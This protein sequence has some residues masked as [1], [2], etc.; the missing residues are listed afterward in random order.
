MHEDREYAESFGNVAEIYER[1]RPGY[2][3]ALLQELIATAP[4]EVLDVGC[5]TG[6]LAVEFM[7][8][9]H[10]LG[11]EPDR[12]MAAVAAAR[13]VEVEIAHFEDWDPAG[14]E[15]RPDRVGHGLA[16]GRASGGRQ[17]GGG[18]PHRRWPL[19][20]D[21]EPL[22]AS[23]RGGGGDAGCLP[24][25]RAAATKCRARRRTAGPPRGRHP[26]RGPGRRGLHRR[27]ARRAGVLELAA[28]PHTPD[29]WLELLSSMTDHRGLE[30]GARE[31]LFARLRADLGRIAP[32]FEVTMVTS[33]IV[34]SR[35]R[36]RAGDWNQRSV[37]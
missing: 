15:I 22:A 31:A 33:A 8:S 9:P 11:V 2:A 35:G 24:G 13:G 14:S 16:L 19:C 27:P 4:N 6:K 26:P 18:D 1:A 7:G 23:T 20:S 5:G 21:V 30:A 29:S 34:A 36:T 12:R 25:A 17:E 3:P 10:V 37:S 32:Q 28:Q